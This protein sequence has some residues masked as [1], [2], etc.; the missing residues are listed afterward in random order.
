MIENLELKLEGKIHVTREEL[1]ELVSSWGR[2]D[3][4]MTFDDIIVVKC[5]KNECYDLS[6]LDVSK[7]NTE[8]SL[9]VV[10]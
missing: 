8:P 5:K 7:S 6:N 4:F 9:I 2:K 3:S 10:G 1:F